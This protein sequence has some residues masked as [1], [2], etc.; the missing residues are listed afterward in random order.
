M[1]VAVA[2]SGAPHRSTPTDAFSAARDTMVVIDVERG[3]DVV[4]WHSGRVVQAPQC[5]GEQDAIVPLAARTWPT[6]G[7]PGSRRSCAV[8]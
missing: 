7:P 6:D 5:L 3:A 1:A 2:A 8:V 4:Q